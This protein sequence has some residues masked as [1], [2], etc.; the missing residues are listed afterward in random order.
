MRNNKGFT[1]V[2]MLVTLAIASITLR[3]AIPATREFQAS[4]RVNSTANDFVAALKDAR[5]RA[6]MTS[7]HETVTAISGAVS[8]NNWGRN[9]WRI[10][11]IRN[12]VVSTMFEYKNV[13]QSVTI[14]SIPGMS[15]F[16]FAAISGQAQYPNASLLNVVFRVCDTKGLSER[17]RD[18]RIN[19]FG[20]ISIITHPNGTLC[21][22]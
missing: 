18:I 20:Q 4:M 17:G 9:G 19:Q 10:T 16:R 13:P 1:L 12:G 11:E 15:A 3:Y 14:T 22:S 2:E 5:S 21:N 8:A 6:V 7:R